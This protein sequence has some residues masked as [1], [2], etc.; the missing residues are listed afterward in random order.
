MEHLFSF[1]YSKAS[2]S[3]HLRTRIHRFHPYVH[4]AMARTILCFELFKTTLLQWLNVIR[5][6]HIFFVLL[7]PVKGM[8][9]IQDF[10]NTLEQIHW[11]REHGNGSCQ[12]VRCYRLLVANACCFALTH[13][14][15]VYM[16]MMGVHPSEWIQLVMGDYIEMWRY[17]PVFPVTF[18]CTV[19]PYLNIMTILYFEGIKTRNYPI[20]KMMLVAEQTRFRFLFNDEQSLIRMRRDGF[21]ILALLQFFLVIA[22][23]LNL[24]NERNSRLL[25]YRNSF[26]DCAVLWTVH[27]PVGLSH[28]AASQHARSGHHACHSGHQLHLH[29]FWHFHFPQGCA[30]CLLFDQSLGH[31]TEHQ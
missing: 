23:K 6:K 29:R 17:P 22:G 4:R 26:S 3:F 19:P 8:N 14:S 13:L 18:V 7:N 15:L 31:P 27:L 24:T 9:Y 20:M 11:A 12:Q 2:D 28:L 5:F 10:F 1:A 25:K 16:M 30:V 21:R